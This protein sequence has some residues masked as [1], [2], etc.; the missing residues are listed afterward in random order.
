MT[1]IAL[2]VDD[3]EASLRLY[4]LLL[5]QAG[6]VVVS[7]RNGLEALRIAVENEPDLVVTDMRLP[8]VS[9]LEVIRQIRAHRRLRNTA[10]IVVTAVATAESRRRS[11][12]AGRDQES[13]QRREGHRAH[14]DAS[15]GGA[16]ETAAH[17]RQEQE[18]GEAGGGDQ[19]QQREHAILA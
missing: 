6:M 18:A 12:E 5:E 4:R 3:D 2:I 10:I 17:Q 14:T 11:E 1:S 13:R 16:R 9:G 8:L 7:A 19:P 15:D